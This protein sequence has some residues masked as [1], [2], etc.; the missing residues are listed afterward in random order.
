[1]GVGAEKIIGALGAA[2]DVRATLDLD[3]A[4]RLHEAGVIFQIPA[5]GADQR[6][7]IILPQTR[8]GIAGIGDGLE[9]PFKLRD[10]AG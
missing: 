10:E 4:P 9:F 3:L 6:I 8:L 2:R 7:E 1:M 5:E